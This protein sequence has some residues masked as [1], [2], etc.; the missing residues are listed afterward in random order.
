MEKGEIA[1]Y[2]QFLLFPQC[3]P[4]ACSPGASKGVIVWE[5]V[6]S[7]PSY[8]FLDWFKLKV[9]ANNTIN[10]GEKLKFALGR[11]ENIVG[12]GENAGYQQFL[13][14]TQCFEKFSFT[15]SLKFRIVW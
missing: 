14:F 3:F 13:L 10:V 12:K 2:E 5:L 6:N 4:K 1:R 8:K 11:V 7:L 9:I 15:R